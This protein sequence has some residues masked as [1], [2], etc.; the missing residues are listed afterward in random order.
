[1]CDQVEEE[2]KRQYKYIYIYIYIHTCTRPGPEA[3][4]EAQKK[5]QAKRLGRKNPEKRGPDRDPKQAHDSPWNYVTSARHF[6]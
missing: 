4:T 5:P 1:M 6:Q 3:R 2:K